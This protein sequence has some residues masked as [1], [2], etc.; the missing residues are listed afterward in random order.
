M[1]IKENSTVVLHYKGTLEDGTIFDSSYD[2][3]EPVEF[4]LGNEELIPGF[5]NGLLNHEKGDK[6]AISIEPEDA[7]GEYSND[8]IFEVSLDEVPEEIQP[9]VGLVLELNTEDG[10]IEVTIIDVTDTTIMLDANH[11][12]AGEKLNFDIEIIDIK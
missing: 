11:S 8:L 3:G 9:E 12:L 7:Y 10:D 1:S 2:R 5:E 6:F 4:T